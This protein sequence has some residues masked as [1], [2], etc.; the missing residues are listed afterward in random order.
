MSWFNH[1]IA[2]VLEKLAVEPAIGL[3]DEEAVARLTA[4]GSN[5]LPQTKSELPIVKFLK[6]FHDVLISHN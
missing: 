6:H 5:E 2:D 1:E 4:H 3:S